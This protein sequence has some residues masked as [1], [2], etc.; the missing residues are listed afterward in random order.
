MGID[1]SI[2]VGHNKRGLDMKRLADLLIKLGAVN[3]INL[4]GGGSSAMAF[5]HELI[6][7]PSDNQP[8]SCHASGEYQCERPVSTVLCIHD[9][10]EEIIVPVQ[11]SIAS[12]AGLMFGGCILFAIGSLGA[13][14]LRQYRW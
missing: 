13:L 9:Q 14:A 10:E 12:T 11:G 1:G 2:A 5:D 4:D 3:A 8:P 7:Y 6:N